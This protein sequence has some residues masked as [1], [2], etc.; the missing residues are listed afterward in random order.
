MENLGIDVKLLIA[1][2]VNFAIF[3]IVFKLLIAEPFMKYLKNEKKKEEER[4]VMTKKLQEGETIL[5]GKEKEMLKKAKAEGD[6]IIAKAKE[7]AEKVK[8]DII[9]EA[10]KQAEAEIA[11]A[12]EQITAEREAMQKDVKNQ[13]ITVSNLIVQKGLE[14]YLTADAQKQV[15]QNVLK[16]LPEKFT[17]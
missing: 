15:T 1:Q 4:E 5:E 3:F 11:K 13:V 7:D 16:H 17:A 8:E 6:E 12:K 2:L 14:D 10:H 9:A